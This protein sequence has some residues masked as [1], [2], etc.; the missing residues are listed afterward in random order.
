MNTPPPPGTRCGLDTVEI[1]RVEHLLRGKTEE[2]LGRLF[3]PAELGEADAAA[4]RTA[5]LAARFAAKEACCKLFPRETAL[6]TI[7]AADF[8]LERDPYG[9]PAVVCSAN[10]QAVLDRQFIGEI[11]VSLTHTETSASAIAWASRRQIHVPWHGAALYHLFPYRRGVVLGNLRRVFGD[12]LSEVE[13]RRLAKAYYGHY[14][15][16][17]FEFVRLPFMSA[18]RRNAWIRVENMEVPLR[19][20]QKGKGV[21]FLTGHFGKSRSTAAISI[22]FGAL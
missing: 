21:I 17:F 14:V 7:T 15:R 19:A 3:S 11:R 2:E 10:A 5:S 16:F 9:A 18:E 13:I 6:G 4:S 20:Y 1:A 22:S 8:S 12:T